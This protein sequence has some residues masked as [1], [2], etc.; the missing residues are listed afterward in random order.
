MNNFFGHFN[1]T[2]FS[3]NNYR[4]FGKDNRF[5]INFTGELYNYSELFSDL[6]PGNNIVND[7]STESLIY[8]LFLNRGIKFASNLN[9]NFTIS[10]A[11][12][13]ENT[14][15]LVRDQI[16]LS[17]LYFC[18]EGRSLYFSDNIKKLFA[19]CPQLEKNIDINALNYYFTYRYIPSDLTI[20]SK[21][22]KLDPGSI[23]IYN[24]LNGG[25]EVKNY[26]K[27]PLEEAKGGNETELAEQLDEL[28]RKSISRRLDHNGS[29]CALLSGGLDSSLN[30]ALMREMG[31]ERIK[32]YTVGFD[33]IDYDE[34]SYSRL[35][36]DHFGTDHSEI[37]IDPDPEVFDRIG[38]IF[39]EPN[40]DP[41][42]FPTYHL[43]GLLDG[44]CSNVI[45]GDG[46]DGLFLG[47]KTHQILSSYVRV[48]PYLKGIYPLVRYLSQYLPDSLRWKIF[49]EGLTPEQ[50]FLRR[51]TY[52]S[53]ED[54]KKLFKHGIPE[55]LDK[56]FDSPE[57]YGNRRVREYSGSTLGKA[58]YFTYSSNPHDI[59]VKMGRLMQFS[60]VNIRTPFLDKDVVSF[61][62]GS[63]GAEHKI[64]NG[65]SKYILKKIAKRYLPPELPVERKRGFNPP[66]RRWIGENWWD[67]IFETITQGKSE[68]IDTRYA[69]Y[70]L[71]N[72][73][74]NF[75]DESRRI[76]PLFMFRLW[77]KRFRDN[78][79]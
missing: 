54:R 29:G 34:T 23:L 43:S 53:R 46:A 35:V 78:I 3:F 50:F 15:Y 69:E 72:H 71:K 13:K 65:I 31:A 17:R 44:Q 26:W 57:S 33:D 7:K 70:L 27:P 61:A 25:L 10:I 42:I 5:K 21:I 62:L 9:G 76:F 51:R 56:K 55:E 77:E 1:S 6:V 11:D 38:E 58:G 63:I 37:V 79:L 68:Y 60:N 41:S 12:R 30:I 32:T 64:N 28:L 20:F 74:K 66:V 8:A 52:F 22:R 19:E 14:L 18:K 47:L 2:D 45:C 48:N 24:A 49:L 73:R 36:S 59:L 16:G 40:G 39:E 4:D 67:Y 75:F